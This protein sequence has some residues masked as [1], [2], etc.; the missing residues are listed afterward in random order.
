[1]PEVYAAQG[2]KALPERGIRSEKRPEFGIA[3]RPAGRIWAIG[4][5]HGDVRRLERLHDALADRVRL[6]DR[7]VYLGN[8]IGHGV[9]IKET[10]DE[11]LR[12]RQAYLARPPFVHPDDILYLRGQQEEIWQKL[13]QLQFAI[14]PL[15]VL[16]WAFAHGAEATLRAYGGDAETALACARGGAVALTRWAGS[17]RD[18]MRARP[19][20]VSLMN[21]L[22]RSAF[23]PD[24]SLLFVS[25][26]VNPRNAVDRQADAFWW[27]SDGFASIDA[28]F[29]G[30][31]TVVRGFDPSRGG[32]KNTPWTVNLDGGCGFGGSLI[33]ACF[34]PNGE[35]RSRLD[36]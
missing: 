20:H 3:M 21:G 17:L 22:H 8:M 36:A 2:R 35:L 1:M 7:I 19:G 27:D 5:V 11:L 15:E 28:P 30:F 25:T 13:Q 34:A 18:A 14:N 12:F 9:A 10:V 33:A 23:T 6:G 4:A 26:G 31:R 16:R 29:D 24:R 32:F